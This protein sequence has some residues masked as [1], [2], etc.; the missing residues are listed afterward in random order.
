[1][2][3]TSRCIRHLVELVDTANSSV[4]KDESS[5]VTAPWKGN[6]DQSTWLDLSWQRSRS[7]EEERAGWGVQSSRDERFKDELF[8]IRI[9]R[10]VSG[11]TDGR[12]PFAG[13]VDSS[14]SDLVN[15]LMGSEAQKTKS[16]SGQRY[17]SRSSRAYECKER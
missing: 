4:G 9:S 11:Q 5:P 12:G 16:R 10:N 8:R 6:K 1:V 3:D 15:V 7:S 17:D 14:R 2:Q 13:S